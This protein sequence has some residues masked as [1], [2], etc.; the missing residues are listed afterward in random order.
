MGLSGESMESL[1]GR[2]RG[3]EALRRNFQ[4]YLDIWRADGFVRMF[5]RFLSREKIRDRLL[6]HP[7]GD[8]RLTNVLHIGEILQNISVERRLGVTGLVK[9]LSEQRDPHA[10]RLEEHQL[11]LESDAHAVTIATIHRSKGL[12]YDTVFCPF[13][14]EGSVISDCPVVFHRP[15]AA[16]RLCL[17]LGSENCEEHKRIA[18]NELLSENLRIL[19]VAVTRAKRKCYLVWGRI[20]GAET[21][22]PAYLFHY[23]ASED[24]PD[25]VSDLRNQMRRKRPEEWL[26]DIRR[27]VGAS[28]GAISFRSL[29]PEH[30]SSDFQ[31]AQNGVSLFGRHFNGKIGSAW[32]ISSYSSWIDPQDA[33]LEAPDRDVDP[34]GDPPDADVVSVP[35]LFSFPRGVR[36]GLFF[37][38]ILE[39]AGAASADDRR[40]LIRTKLN[41]YGFDPDWEEAVF[42]MIR[43]VFSVPLPADMP[44]F[45]LSDVAPTHRIHEMAFHFP[46]QPV[47]AAELK[48]IFTAYGGHSIPEGFSERL[49]RLAYSP[50]AGFMKGYVDLVFEHRG[51]FFLV[52][53]KSNYL[54]PRIEDYRR[55]AL[56]PVMMEGYY[57]LQYYLYALALDRYLA[58]RVPGYRYEARFGGIFYLFLRGMDAARGP[59]FGVFQDVPNFR[60]IA[61]LRSALIPES[62]R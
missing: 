50:A 10:P 4:E 52:D 28:G 60:I 43:Q 35:N 11:R 33:D 26:A 7:D 45:S 54:G 21:A 48:D 27:V 58:Q 25:V 20:R 3:W 34:H 8:R 37:H 29:P 5:R 57:Y 46:L 14:W 38:D 22:A 2:D 13:A 31:P 32:K 53:W 59:A 12:E 55:E 36:A 51:K 39:N 6:S 47:P 61:A 56:V 62:M 16:K 19:Y 42:D 49:G 44:S 18:Q 15:D 24:S 1:D 9:W 41:D 30:R 23:T 17:D 40:S